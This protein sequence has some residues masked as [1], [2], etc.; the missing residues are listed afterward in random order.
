LA[1]G[2]EGVGVSVGSGVSVEGWMVTVSA[3]GVGGLVADEGQQ[4]KAQT[5]R[6]D[7]QSNFFMVLPSRKLCITKGTPTALFRYLPL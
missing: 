3:T 7:R 4:A 1:N 6:A 2:G 5:I